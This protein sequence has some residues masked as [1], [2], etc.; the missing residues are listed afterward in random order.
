MSYTVAQRTHEIGIRLALGAQARD[1]LRLVLSQ[2]LV[3]TLVG[4]AIGGGIAFWITRFMASI[5][6]HGTASDPLVFIGVA[7][8]LAVAALLACFIPAR[9][10][11]KVDP[12]V[13]LRYE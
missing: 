11:T 4:L 5:L 6:Y 8:V 1:I 7:V 3:L 13:A 12:M 9:R 10:A 2:G